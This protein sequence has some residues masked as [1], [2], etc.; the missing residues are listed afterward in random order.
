MTTREASD[1]QEKSIEHA[2]DG[3]RTPNS[4]GTK[5][6]GGDVIVQ[7][8]SMF[9]EAKTSMSH[10]DSFSIKREWLDKAVEQK[11]EQGLS[12]WALAFRFGPTDVDY[13]VLSKVQFREY[14]ELLR[15][16]ND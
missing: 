10:K 4:G 11:Y 1:I 12:R 13:F 9:I 5:F 7:D 3:K 14:L 16:D 2:T 8:V 6:G 15:K